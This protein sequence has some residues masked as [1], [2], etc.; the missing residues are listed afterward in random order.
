MPTDPHR[1]PTILQPSSSQPQKTQK[2]RKPKRKDTQVPQPS[3]PTNNVAD[4]AVHKELGDRL[5]RV[6]TIASS[7]EA[8]QDS[9]LRVYLNIPMI[10]WS[11]ETKTTQKNE[12]DSLKMMVKKLEKRNRSRTYKMKRLYKGRRIDA[13]DVNEDI[14]LVNDV[15]NEMFDI[16]DLGGEEVFI[17]GHNKNVVEEVVNV[18]QVST[19]ATTVIITTEEITLAQALEA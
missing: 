4:E 1:T 11:Q 19:A 12:I 10:H 13:I 2:S 16:D 15:D 8:D 6:A 5:V 14:T 18:A 7:I 17:V 3:G 9:G